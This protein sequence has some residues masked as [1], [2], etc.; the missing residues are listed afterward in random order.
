VVQSGTVAD[1]PA[2]VVAAYEAPFPE[3]AAKAGA[4]TF[5]LLVP[6]SD[7]DTGAAEMRAVADALAQWV[8]PALIAFSD[9]DPVFPWP[10]AGQVFA[11]LI[12]SAGDPVKIEGGAHFLQDDCGER[13]A[14]ELM[15][16]LG[17]GQRSA[18]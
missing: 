8:K 6:V 13:I 12:P 3:L 11:D 1:L 14:A 17:N 2:D 10:R 15:A 5:P 4:A 18:A 16:F 9:S 7:D